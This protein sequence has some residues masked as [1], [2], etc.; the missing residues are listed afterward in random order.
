MDLAFDV[1]ELQRVIETSR[2]VDDRL[3]RTSIGREMH[4]R[5]ILVEGRLDEVAKMAPGVFCSS[6]LRLMVRRISRLRWLVF[7]MKTGLATDE[8]STGVLPYEEEDDGELASQMYIV[9]DSGVGLRRDYFL[10]LDW[11]SQEE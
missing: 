2:Y 3:W 4:G 8:V 1:V 6:Q 5:C 7:S 10:S 9:I 11:D